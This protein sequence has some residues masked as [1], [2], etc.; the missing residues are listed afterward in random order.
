MWSKGFEHGEGGLASLLFSITAVVLILWPTGQIWP[1][2]LSLGLWVP[3]LVWKFGGGGDMIA[4]NAAPLLP[5]F[6]T[7]GHPCGPDDVDPAC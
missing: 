7:H 5:N 1:V 3:S 2:K 6:I 4:L